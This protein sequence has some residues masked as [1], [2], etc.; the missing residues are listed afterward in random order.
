MIQQT[1]IFASRLYTKKPGQR[2]AKLDNHTSKYILLGYTS[3]NK[4]VY[5]IDDITN[6]NFCF[7]TKSGKRNAKL[8]NHTSNDIFLGYT[9]TSKNVY[10]ID[11]LTHQV[12]MGTH[13]LFDEA[14]F[15]VPASQ[16]LFAVQTLQLL[17]YSNF[18]NEFQLGKFIS[19]TKL[20]I[21]CMNSDV[22]LP[23]TSSSASIGLDV[24]IPRLV[25]V[26]HH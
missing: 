12:K 6:A 9:S 19:S 14:H 4:N 24:F 3:T 8:D 21:T 1:R 2:N 26:Y 5:Y 20:Q 15:T 18:N 25:F 22:I 7:R 10:Y 17:G 23:T 16:T 11:D 13:V